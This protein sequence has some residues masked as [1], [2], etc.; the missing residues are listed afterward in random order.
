MSIAGRPGF[1]RVRMPL[2]DPGHVAQ[3]AD[4]TAALNAD[5]TALLERH[6]VP[7]PRLT[8]EPNPFRLA[9]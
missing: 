2:V 9:R 7:S 4:A 8:K 1:T 5:P 3:I 6:P